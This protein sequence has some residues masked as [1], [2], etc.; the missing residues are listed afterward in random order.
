MGLYSYYFQETPPGG[1][2]AAATTAAAEEFSQE[3][4]A[5]SP[6]RSGTTYPVR[7]SLTPTLDRATSFWNDGIWGG[8]LGGLT[9]SDTTAQIGIP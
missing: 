3:I 4:Q 5:L 1:A 7:V 6:M 2:T 9:S 8:P